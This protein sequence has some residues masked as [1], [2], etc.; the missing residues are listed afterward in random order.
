MTTSHADYATFD[1]KHFFM[2]FYNPRL[3]DLP[4]LS[5]GGRE[6]EAQSSCN[7]TNPSFEILENLRINA[8]RCVLQ[9]FPYVNTIGECIGHCQQDQLC[10]SVQITEGVCTLYSI[11]YDDRPELFEF[12]QVKG[13][14][15]V[16][17]R[18][19][20]PAGCNALWQSELVPNYRLKENI[21]ESIVVRSRGECADRCLVEPRC[22]SAN[23]DGTFCELNIH[24]RQSLATNQNFCPELGVSY[25]ENNC[26]V[27][28]SQVCTF[29]RHE[30]L[31][32]YTFDAFFLSARNEDE[33][34][35]Q[36]TSDPQG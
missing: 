31:I 1:L 21:L 26:I 19:C 32:P 30:N 6:L 7:L 22:K 20:S 36:C 3:M 4:P 25:I 23:Y 34:K 24:S 11:S 29:E 14:H 35:A 16:A 5:R 2:S 33:C 28:P 27:E 9:E 15:V 17:Q 12:S 8:P 13:L 10:H 18:R